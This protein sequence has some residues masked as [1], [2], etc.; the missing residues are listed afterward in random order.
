MFGFRQ[1]EYFQMEEAAREPIKVDFK[2]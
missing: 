1:H 2:Q